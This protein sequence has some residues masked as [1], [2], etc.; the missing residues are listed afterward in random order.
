[1][2]TDRVTKLTRGELKFE[3]LSKGEVVG[4]K[5]TLEAVDKMHRKG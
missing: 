4:L 2:W 5:E 3:L 1:M